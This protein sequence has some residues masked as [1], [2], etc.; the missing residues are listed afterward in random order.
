[1]TQTDETDGR[2]KNRAWRRAWPA[3][4]SPSATG[5]RPAGVGP[6]APVWTPVQ[7]AVPGPI[8]G[9]PVQVPL[10]VMG[11]SH[12]AEMLPAP[13]HID[14]SF[15]AMPPLSNVWTGYPMAANRNISWIEAERPVS[16]R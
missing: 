6:A 14:H 13:C 10:W 12:S 8:V 9:V 3:I 5:M 1:M 7:S 2:V 16:V 4:H 11:G 15:A